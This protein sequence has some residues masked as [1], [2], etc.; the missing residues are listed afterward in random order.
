MN[1]NKPKPWQVIRENKSAFLCKDQIRSLGFFE[2]EID[3]IGFAKSIT[4]C[5]DEIFVRPY[6]YA[7]KA[8]GRAS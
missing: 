3:A 7:S 4:L 8:E 5:P 1:K 2:S 6:P